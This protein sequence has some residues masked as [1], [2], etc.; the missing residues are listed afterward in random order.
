MFELGVELGVELGGELGVELGVHDEDLRTFLNLQVALTVEAAG[1]YETCSTERI[2]WWAVRR[3]VQCAVQ[4]I[5]VGKHMQ[6]GCM[7]N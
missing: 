6:C 2:V 5:A 1:L 7:P 4:C 3:T